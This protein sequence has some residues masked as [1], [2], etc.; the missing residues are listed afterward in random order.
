MWSMNAP[1]K[2]IPLCRFEQPVFL[3]VV[4]VLHDLTALF[5][6]KRRNGYRAG[7]IRFERSKIVFQTR[8]ERRVRHG[9]RWPYRIQHMTHHAPI[10]TNVVLFGGLAR[11]RRK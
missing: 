7:R 11:P 9:P 1:A 2:A 8:D 5:F 3:L 10:H 6:T 4:K